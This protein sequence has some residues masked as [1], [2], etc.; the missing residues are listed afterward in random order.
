MFSHA[1][2]AGDGTSHSGWKHVFVEFQ[3]KY[4]KKGFSIKV[5]KLEPK[6]LYSNHLTFYR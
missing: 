4:K 2:H 1:P 6:T 5:K 3:I